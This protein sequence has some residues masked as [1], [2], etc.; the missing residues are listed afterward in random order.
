MKIVVISNESQ[1]EE[2]NAGVDPGNSNIRWVS[3]IGEIEA[4]FDPDVIIDLLFDEAPDH[5]SILQSFHS[6]LIMINSVV[7]TLEETDPSFVRLNGWNGFLGKNIIEA[8]GNETARQIATEALSNFNKTIEWVKDIPGFIGPR[9]I[10]MIIN[11]AF[12]ALQEDVS[13]KEEINTAMKLGTNYPFGP[14]EWVEKIGAYKVKNLL[15]RL[16][17]LDS[18]YAPAQNFQ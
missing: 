14:F 18:K 13:T 16:S 6:K 8:A 15:T 2:L 5:R 10:S 3:S 4:S 12:L 11:E 17:I 7:E 1:K 9:V